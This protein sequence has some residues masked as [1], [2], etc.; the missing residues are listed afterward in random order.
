MSEQTHLSPSKNKG[1]WVGVRRP[2]LRMQGNAGRFLGRDRSKT[3]FPTK[4]LR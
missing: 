4:F 3:M 2:A 1:S